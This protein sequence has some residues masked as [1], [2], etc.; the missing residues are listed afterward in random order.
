M[1][2]AAEMLAELA[3]EVSV[4]Q[5]CDLWRGRTQTVFGEGP[6]TAE[7]MFIGEGPGEQEDRPGRP[8][9]GAA[10]QV[11]SQ[12]LAHAGLSRSEVYIANLVKCRPPQ[13]REPRPEE[14][15]SCRPYLEA[16]IALLNP[17]I[18]CLLGRPATQAM[19]WPTASISKVHGV[20]QE[21]EGLLYLPLY[22]P[23]AALHQAKLQPVLVA[24]MQRLRELLERRC[25]S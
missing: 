17:K 20:P 22:H 13:N 14:V 10:G 21:R 9:V 8:F 23:A 15:A 16:Q 24:D 25:D 4:C 5:R 2:D 6:P 19:L 11:L 7:I 1:A 3:E 18:I 12:L